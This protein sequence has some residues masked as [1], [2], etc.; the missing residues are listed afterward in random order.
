M[1]R[2]AIDHFNRSNTQRPD[3]GLEVVSSLL[4]NFR[5]HPEGCADKGIALRLD[6]DQ[7]RRD[8]EVGQLHFSGI[9][10]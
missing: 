6:I 5:S 1:R 10:E 9:R 2:L 7:L 3:I 8:T 4:D